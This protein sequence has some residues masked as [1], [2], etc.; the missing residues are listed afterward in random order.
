[1]YTSELA[2]PAETAASARPQDP[3]RRHDEFRAR[4]R[5]FGLP[6]GAHRAVVTA[7]PLV[8]ADLLAA[9]GS[10][11]VAWWQGT[12]L[13]PYARLDW[14]ALAAGF[15]AAIYVANMAVGLYPGI[16]LS[17]FAETRQASVAVACIGLFFLTVSLLQ[18][19]AM[20]PIQLAILATCVSLL[21]AVPLARAMARWAFGRFAW[22]G[23]RALIVGGGGGGAQSIYLFLRQNPRFGLRPLG[24]I[25]DDRATEGCAETPPI[26]GSLSHAGA[27]ARELRPGWLVFAA[28]GRPCDEVQKLVGSLRRDSSYQAVITWLDGSPSLWRR[29]SQ[30]LDWPG[31]RERP[32]PTWLLTSA[33]RA[34]DLVLAV[35]GGLLLLPLMIAIAALIKIGSPGPAIYRQERVGQHGRRFLVCKFRTM[36]CDGDRVLKEYLAASPKRQEQ[37]ER[38]HKLADD[39][40]VTPIGLWLRKTSLDE[41]PQLWNVVRG[42]MSL[43]GPRP[44][45]ETE[46][47][48]FGS[49]F[50]AFCSVLPG[51]TGL[52]Q[53]SGR[54][55]TTYEEHVELDRYYAENWSLWLDLYILLLTVRVVLLRHGAY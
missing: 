44:I 2:A 15:I 48:D 25:D 42:E 14:A 51:I 11:T 22:W 28:S 40:R 19:R 39:P 33:K 20:L 43:V 13:W 16:G 4:N 46:I 36:I 32:S 30:C 18:R 54:N 45:L 31:K 55:Q 21:V 35:V 7:L 47:A 27:V 17:T 12:A 5:A 10:F 37:W 6:S 49:S 9:L 50:A 26:L 8:A 41:L 23:E 38:D 29:A 52:W 1:M 3:D 24:I 53:V 34:T